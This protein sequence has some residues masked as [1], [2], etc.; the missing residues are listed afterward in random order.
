MKKLFITL[1]CSSVD[2]YAEQKYN[3]CSNEWET[4]MPDVQLKFNTFSN[5][6]EFASPDASPKFNPYANKYEMTHLM[7]ATERMR[8][9]FLEREIAM[10]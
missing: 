2:A 5:K 10:Q 9:H 1:I 6:N 4:V 8:L 3:P 7:E